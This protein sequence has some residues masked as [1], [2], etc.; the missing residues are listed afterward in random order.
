MKLFQKEALRILW[1]FY[2]EY[3]IASALYF[4]P[5]FMVVY[6]LDIGLSAFRIG[7]LIGVLPLTMLIFEIPTGA[8]ADLYGRKVSVLFGYFIEA[9]SMISLFFWDN[10][11]LMLFSFAL[12]GFGATF[13]SGS[14]DAWIVDKLNKKNKNYVHNFF[15]GMQLFLGLGL[16]LSGI[17]GALL[18]KTYGLR[19]IWLVTFFSYCS[20]ILLIYFLTS[21]DYVKKKV[22]F[23]KPFFDL[24]EKTKKS[25]DYC[26]Q[27]HVLFFL[28]SAGMI[29]TFSFSLQGQIAWV[30]YL[31]DLGMKDYHYGYLWSAMALLMAISPL[32]FLKFQKKNN[33][34]NL[35][36]T[37]LIFLTLILALIIFVSNLIFALMILL[38]TMMFYYSILP[39]QESY[40]YRFIP[41]LLRAS[42]GSVRNMMYSIIGIIVL[43]LEGFLVDNIGSKNTI[44][45]SAIIMIPAII[46]YSLINDNKKEQK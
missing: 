14:K 2:L 41:S 15:I 25:L 18:V 7:I 43:P 34:R 32:L 35:I 42:V 46:L 26:Y 21:E 33:E 13:S 22:N 30:P 38:L 28:I 27:H 23:K 29:V 45:I 44:L 4:M 12:F 37:G 1:P 16:I 11:W 40:F 8:F 19:I 9:I 24:N 5:V 3:F 6:F 17:I 10:F 20:S 31:K 36:I 39:S